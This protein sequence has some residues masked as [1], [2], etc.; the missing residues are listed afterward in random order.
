MKVFILTEYYWSD[1]DWHYVGDMFGLFS[2]YKLACACATSPIYAED[3]QPVD[4]VSFCRVQEW[5]VCLPGDLQRTDPK[6]GIRGATYPVR[7][8]RR[9]PDEIARE[10]LAGEHNALEREKQEAIKRA[11]TPEMKL[12]VEQQAAQTTAAQIERLR[13]RRI[14]R[15]QEGA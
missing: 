9:S 15:T 12:R 1:D 4:R 2:T 10:K 11:F 6:E 13:A 8:K 7:S 14:R 5:R 3:D